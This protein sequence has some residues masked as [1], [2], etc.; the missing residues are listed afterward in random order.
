LLAMSEGLD[1]SADSA[2]TTSEL[3]AAY[4]RAVSDLSAATR[5]PV[6]ARHERSLRAALEHTA[7]HYAEP[8]RAADVARVAGFAPKYFS[9]LF[10]EHEGTTFEKHL[11]GL[12]VERAQFL[13]ASSA[14]DVE[15]VARLSGFGSSQYFCRVF[16]RATG[17]TPLGYRSAAPPRRRAASRRG[18]G[19]RARGGAPSAWRRVTPR[20][21]GSHD[22]ASVLRR[23]TR[24]P[25]AS[26]TR[27]NAAPCGP[28]WRAA[29]QPQPPS[30]PLGSDPAGLAVA[31]PVPAVASLDGAL[32]VPAVASLDGAPPVPAVASARAAPPAPRP[33]RNEQCPPCR[34]SRRHS[35]FRPRRPRR[36]VR[37]SRRRSRERRCARRADRTSP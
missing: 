29:R 26:A 25:R 32:P 8:L 14:L 17:L 3:L 13:L 22:V 10:R 2:R 31:P 4:R 23:H 6:A 24:P 1:R 5:K 36:T 18:E 30:S 15:R 9:R 37:S 27:A 20:C 28:P 12:R 7:Q 19:T 34:R 35:W 16:R 11:R 33:H 21:G